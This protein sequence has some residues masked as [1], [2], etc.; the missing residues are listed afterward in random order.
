MVTLNGVGTRDQLTGAP[1]NILPLLDKTPYL[2]A[3]SDLSPEELRFATR[4]DGEGK[5]QQARYHLYSDYYLGRQRDPRKLTYT[6]DDETRERSFR[7]VYNVCAPIVDILVE[8]LTITSFSATGSTETATALAHTLWDWWQALRMDALAR[9]V[10]RG[11]LTAGD[12]YLMCEWPAGA[13]LPN[14]YLEDAA[15][16]RVVYD[17]QRQ[18]QRAYKAWTEIVDSAGRTRIRVNRYQPGLI[19]KFEAATAAG[20]VANYYA[21]DGDEGIIAW[22]DTEGPLPIPIIHFRNMPHGGDFGRSELADAVPMQDQY[23][24]RAWATSQAAI[25]DGART[26]YGINVSKLIHPTTG[27]P[28]AP[29]LGPNAFWYVTPEDPDKA[30]SIG[31]LDVGAVDQLQEVVDRLL[32]TIAGLLGIPVHLIWPAGGLPSGESL[33]TAEGRLVSKLGDRSVVFGNAW[34]DFCALLMRLGRAFAGVEYAPNSTITTEWQSFESRS[35]LL[36]EQVLDL[37]ASDLSWEQR[38]RERDYSEEEIDRIRTER[39]GEQTAVVANAP[40][41]GGSDGRTAE[42]GNAGG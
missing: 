40:V 19:E 23:N 2:V 16:I 37:R 1:V 15:Q 18:M 34:E 33:K 36:E 5:D 21:G 13:P 6:S 25:F 39:A 20:G 12:A 14:V 4:Q 7:A 27:E 35:A 41:G 42:Q 28:I 11:C 38:M 10:H 3:P 8:R 32:K 17:N 24:L 22:A 29:P 31:T 30:V 26:K 9:D